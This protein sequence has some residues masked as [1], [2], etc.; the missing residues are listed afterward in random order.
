MGAV[1]GKNGINGCIYFR[2]IQ[3]WAVQRMENS[4]DSSQN[5]SGQG[6]GEELAFTNVTVVTQMCQDTAIPRGYFKYWSEFLGSD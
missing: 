2:Q 5:S 6:K 3:T 1:G 4:E